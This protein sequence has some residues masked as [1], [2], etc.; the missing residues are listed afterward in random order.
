MRTISNP[1]N[2]HNERPRHSALFPQPFCSWRLLWLQVFPYKSHTLNDIRRFPL[3]PAIHPCIF[4]ITEKSGICAWEFG[5]MVHS[6]QLIS[7]DHTCSSPIL[8]SPRR[9][10]HD[11]FCT[12]GSVSRLPDH[13][14]R[15]YH[16]LRPKDQSLP[17]RKTRRA[18]RRRRIWAASKSLFEAQQMLWPGCS[19]AIYSV[20][21]QSLLP[22][23]PAGFTVDHSNSTQSL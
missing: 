2:K 18:K 16:D 13:R 10:H 20:D 12:H 3:T 4:P 14:I 15:R 6:K 22:L 21:S 19:E 23:E 7:R 1:Y 8:K 5:L 17:S 11:S 9:F